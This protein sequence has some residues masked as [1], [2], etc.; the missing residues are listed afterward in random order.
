MEVISV[1]FHILAVR[2]GGRSM[3]RPSSGAMGSGGCTA[4]EWEWA[5][6]EERGE[7]LEGGRCRFLP[8]RERRFRFLPRLRRRGHF[9]F[10]PRCMTGSGWP[11]GR[12]PHGVMGR[13]TAGGMATP[14]GYGSRYGRRDGDSAVVGESD[15]VLPFPST[16]QTLFP[17]P[18][19]S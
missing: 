18:S 8:P 11:A 10:L 5:A 13:G 4:S 14:R 16:V 15:I 2:C 19:A 12:R 3:L 1:S 9:H 6:S 7:R 17:F